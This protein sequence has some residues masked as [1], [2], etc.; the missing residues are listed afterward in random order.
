MVERR[1]YRFRAW[2]KEDQAI[3]PVIMVG[4]GVVMVQDALSERTRRIGDVVLMQ[5]TGLRDIKDREIYESDIVELN[6]NGST[7]RKQVSLK[8]GSFR[9]AGDK[10]STIGP[11]V[12]TAAIINRHQARVIG[13]IYNLE[14]SKDFQAS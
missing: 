6:H 12:L 5:Y 2:D 10:S 13:D 14:L 1:K 8:D 3:Y 7:I 9:L 11:R 4:R